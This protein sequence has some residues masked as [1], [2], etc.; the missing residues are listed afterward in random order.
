[1]STSP[2][3]D[4]PKASESFVREVLAS[5]WLVTVLAIVIALLVGAILIAFSD[6]KVQETAGYFFA[7]PTDFFSAVWDKVSTAYVAMFRGAFFDWEAKT[8][9]L[10]FKPITETLVFA[11]PLI[12]AGLAVAVPFRAGMFNIGA[13]GQ[14]VLGALGAGYI[15]YMFS[16]PP[17]V[18]VTLAVLG[19]TLAGAVWAGISGWLKAATGAN[20]VI[21][22]IMLNNVAVYLIAYLLKQSWFKGNDTALPQSESIDAASASLPLLIGAPFRVHGGF[23]VAI[24]A[25]VAVWW[26]MERST[27]GFEF[28]AVGANASAARTAGISVARTTVLVMVISGMLAGLAGANQILGTSKM[29]TASIAGSI[30]FD[31][32][33][34]ALLGRSKPLGVF[35]AG[36]LFG[37]LKAGG[38]TMQAQTNTPIDIVLVV[39][40]V[41]VLLVAA[42]PLVRAI[43]RLPAPGAARVKEVAA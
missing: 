12:M 30:G 37:A 21:T 2:A 42:P 41:I 40:S 38:Y 1:M 19:G 3:P 36:L 15:G 43:F 31:A 22:T 16:L 18:H 13:N 17:V 8:T 4:K 20:E 24:L 29:L 10:K 34:V 39:Q 5:S 33:T 32:I 25:A 9:A 11:T 27:L 14:V 7:R 35:G 28:R 26:L 6:T 23:L